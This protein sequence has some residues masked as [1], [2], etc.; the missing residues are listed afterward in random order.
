MATA[1]YS[2]IQI[3]LHW[4]IFGLFAL[5]YVVSDD[6]GRAL[7]TK[8]EGG[9][10][11]QF[12]AL[13]H[14]PVGIAILALMAIRL[15]VRALQGAPAL[16]PAEKPWMDLAAK[17]GHIALYVL[18]FAVPLSGIAAWGVG[19]RAAGEA[20]EV[21][22]NLAILAVAGHVLAALYHQFILRDGLMKRM[23]MRP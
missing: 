11:E 7:R 21:I 13:V 23:S 5:N 19:I 4:L 6:M 22:V 2:R 18:L 12:A 1:R 14:P 8:L 3:A 9:T 16:P 17:W 20:H 10:P 15:L